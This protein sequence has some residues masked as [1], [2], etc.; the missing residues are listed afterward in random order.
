[1]QNYTHSFDGPTSPHLGPTSPTFSR[2]VS[3]LPSLIERRRERS[4][5]F[6][7]DI[8]EV[9]T[10][11]LCWAP[12]LEQLPAGRK[13]SLI[14]A[15][16][17]CSEDGQVAKYEVHHYDV[18]CVAYGP[19]SLSQTIRFC[20]KLRRQ[21]QIRDVEQEGPIIL[22]TAGK[23]EERAV[24]A[25]LLGAFLAFCHN[26][27]AKQIRE[28]LG[29]REAKQKFPCSWARMVQ[30]D[31]DLV[32]TVQCCWE[33]FEEAWKH[34]WLD[35][36]CLNDDLLMDIAC[37]KYDDMVAT[38]DAAWLVPNELLVSSDPVTTLSD[39][40]PE[41]CM[42]MLPSE[43]G[44]EHKVSKTDSVA[45]GGAMMTSMTM[46]RAS[47][48]TGKACATPQSFTSEISTTTGTCEPPCMVHED[49]D[50]ESDTDSVCTVNKDYKTNVST[51]PLSQ[52]SQGKSYVEF[53]LE[54]R[55]ELVVRANYR[56]E[57]GMMQPSYDGSALAPFGIKHEDVQVLDKHGGLPKREDVARVLKMSRDSDQG[58]GA[59]LFHCK[60]GFGRS[61]VLACCILIV[62]YNVSGRALLGWVRVARPGSITTP[63]QERFLCSLSGAADVLRYAELKAGETESS[64]TTGSSSGCRPGCT[65][66]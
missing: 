53:L 46:R 28:N 9:L 3:P 45:H 16:L 15:L 48:S 50:E 24:G 37:Q 21:L 58:Q 43:K 17:L 44:I 1:M 47:E 66:M 59:I 30:P 8:L 4:A 5:S 7:K 6:S 41:T 60:G 26:W 22:T 35:R 61:V 36:H 56:Q 32:M 40:N 65:V 10:N 52:S 20:R 42:C 55:V 11:R 13:G 19:F 39:P 38:Y 33:G 64:G 63:Q 12:G 57:S 54:C 51:E 25:V 34:G 18:G 29:S 62:R 27:S 23:A 31:A 14:N 49:S 2:Q